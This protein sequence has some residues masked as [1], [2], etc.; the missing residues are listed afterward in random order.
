MGRLCRR[1]L[2]EAFASKV[3]L[4]FWGLL[5]LL[6]FWS[7]GIGFLGEF[8]FAGGFGVYFLRLNGAVGDSVWC[9]IFDVVKPGFGETD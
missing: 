7:W 3:L 9:W 1:W 4:F 6:I 5:W 8:C 2:F